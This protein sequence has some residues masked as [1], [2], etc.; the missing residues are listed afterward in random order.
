[1]AVETG[2]N[3]EFYVDIGDDL[4]SPTWVLLPQQR[5]GSLSLSKTDVDST[6]KENSGWIDSI[7]TRRGW[8]ASVEGIYEDNDSA[9][10]YLIATNDLHASDTDY[11]VGLKLVDAASD[12]YIGATTL[13]SIELAAPESD[14]V[15]YSLSF[16]G[17]GAL[18]LTRA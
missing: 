13:D 14:L 12:T 15:T 17:R 10:D 3:W 8:S 16:T 2:I 9:L 1:M 4:A 5:D 7:S 6:S 11:Q 18:T